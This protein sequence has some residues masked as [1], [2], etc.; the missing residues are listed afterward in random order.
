MAGID[1]CQA[2][3]EADLATGVM[4]RAALVAGEGR[5]LFADFA[6]LK[7]AK[8]LLEPGA[9]AIGRVATLAG[10]CRT[11]TLF[12]KFSAKSARPCRL[13][14]PLLPFAVN[15]GAAGATEAR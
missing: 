4:L 14:R 15:Y 9:L 1:P 5:A 8:S 12:C 11:D 2:V 3:A 6:R 7:Q 10:F 13:S